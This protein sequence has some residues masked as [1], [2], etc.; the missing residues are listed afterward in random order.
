MSKQNHSK[1]AKSLLKRIKGIISKKPS[2]ASTTNDDPNTS[3][4]DEHYGKGM[5]QLLNQRQSKY[6]GSK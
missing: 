4:K 6:H 5:R 3:S 1:P 2:T